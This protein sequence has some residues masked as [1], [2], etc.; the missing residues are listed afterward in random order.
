MDWLE[1]QRFQLSHSCAVCGAEPQIFPDSEKR[2]VVRCIDPAHRGF[3][4]LKGYYERYREGEPIPLFIAQRI[5]R[6]EEMRT[7][8]IDRSKQNTPPE[9][10][11]PVLYEASTGAI[12]AVQATVRA[13]EYAQEV[14]VLPERG[15]IC[16]YHGKPWITIEGWYFLL[17]QKWPDACLVTEPIPQDE[18]ERMKVADNVHTWRAKV[19]DKMGGNLL[20]MGYGYSNPED[21]LAFKSSVEPRWPWRLAEKRAEEDAIRK[22]V[23]L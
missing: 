23:G 14:G 2:Y 19:C 16:L 5:E 7:V 21:P 3:E 12:A 6:K 8:A 9:T 1:A 17:R 4:R 18:R 13:L 20:S 15:H 10:Q 11:L 22:A